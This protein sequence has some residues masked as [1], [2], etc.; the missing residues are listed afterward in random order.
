MRKPDSIEVANFLMERLGKGGATAELVQP[1]ELTSG[2]ISQVAA[3]P[4]IA[5]LFA[6]FVYSSEGDWQHHETVSSVHAWESAQFVS[7]AD[8]L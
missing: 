1:D 2:I 6:A 4:D 8:C 3:E 5:P 7:C